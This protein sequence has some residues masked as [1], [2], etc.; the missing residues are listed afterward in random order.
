[1]LQNEP[2]GR[3]KIRRYRR[4]RGTS[5]SQNSQNS[6]FT[7]KAKDIELSLQSG[8]HGFHGSLGFTAKKQTDEP[9]NLEEALKRTRVGFAKSLHTRNVESGHTHYTQIF[10]PRK[11]L[12]GLGSVLIAKR[13]QNAAT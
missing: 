4:E 12:F 10:P 11:S 13:A 7:R 1:M 3:Q 5:N 6:R 9:R 2:F 8:F